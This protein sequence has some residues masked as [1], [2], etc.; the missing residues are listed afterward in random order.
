L[1]RVLVIHLRKKMPKLDEKTKSE[2]LSR[3][4]EVLK[5]YPSVHLEEFVTHSK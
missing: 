5:K 1:V 3:A 4:Q 2:L